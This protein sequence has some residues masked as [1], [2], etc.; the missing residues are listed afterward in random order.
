ML[1]H[2]PRKRWNS[3]EK[4]DFPLV[5]EW[6]WA[7][8][9]RKIQGTQ[10]SWEPKAVGAGNL[11]VQSIWTS[12][13]WRHEN[14]EMCALIPEQEHRGMSISSA[15]SQHW[16]RLVALILTVC[17]CRG[18][19]SQTPLLRF[20]WSVRTSRVCLHTLLFLLIYLG[21]FYLQLRRSW[22]NCVKLRTVYFKQV[23]SKASSE[24]YIHVRMRGDSFP[25]E[26][27]DKLII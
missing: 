9:E 2:F 12:P 16:H 27:N 25:G 17:P 21:F 1:Y 18:A 11:S 14:T 15:A 7:A 13:C 6:N 20:P 22:I 10:K 4:S 24:I 23:M 19:K 3:E 26:N 8:E 5:V